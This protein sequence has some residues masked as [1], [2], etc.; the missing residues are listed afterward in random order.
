MLILTG[1]QLVIYWILMRA[2]AELSQRDLVTRQELT[3]G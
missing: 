3:L 2:L 1:I